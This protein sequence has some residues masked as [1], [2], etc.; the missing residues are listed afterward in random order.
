MKK[1]LSLLLLAALCLS[2]AACGGSTTSNN[3]QN[4]LPE[5]TL[6]VADPVTIDNYAKFTL[7]KVTS[8]AKIN[9]SLGDDVYYE[10][11]AGEIYVDIVL[12]VTNLSTRDIDCSEFAVATATN[13]TGHTYTTRL[14]LKETN[15]A[16]YLSQYESITPLSTA[17]LHCAI[18]VPQNETDLTLKLTIA[19]CVYVIPYTVGEA[20]NSTQAISIGQTI[21]APDFATMKFVGTEYTDDVVPSDTSSAYSHYEIDNPS[22]TYLVVKLDFTNYASTEKDCDAFAFV[23]AVYMNKYT[24]NGFVAVEDEDQQGFDAY[25]DIAPLATRHFYY[26][27]EVPKT[28]TEAE[29]SITISFN[30]QEYVYTLK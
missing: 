10:T 28:V 4:K 19:K 17:R 20:K 18:T 6:S 27:I 25:E 26:L 8:S 11:D 29:C 24:Y 23:Q 15:D 3:N 2:L 22:N 9:A 21:E 16:H 7:F 5:T 13:Q 12:D 1:L 14:Y 30:S